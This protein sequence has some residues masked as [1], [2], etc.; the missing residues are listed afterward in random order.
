MMVHLVSRYCT[1]WL[2]LD[3]SSFWPGGEQSDLPSSGDTCFFSALL[4]FVTLTTFM[5]LAP[6]S[7][8]V[9]SKPFPSSRQERSIGIG[10]WFSSLKRMRFAER[11]SNQH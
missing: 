3:K 5:P 8:K 10:N 1:K 6:C 2:D 7:M 9:A 11:E 4:S